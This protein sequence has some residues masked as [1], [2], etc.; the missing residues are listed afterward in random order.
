MDKP[1]LRRQLQDKLLA[2]RPE[3]RDR[4]SRQACERLVATEQF[5]NSSTVMLF[6][7]LPY[8]VD[9]SEAIL[10]AWQ[11][12]KTVAVPKVSWE[13]KHMIPVQIK[14]LETGFSTEAL[15][16]RNPTAGVPIPLGDIDLVV[17][18]GLGFDRQGNRLGRGGAYYDRFF[19]H[20]ELRACRCGFAFAEQ[21]IDAL[22]VTEHDQPVDLLVTDKEIM[23]FGNRKG[24]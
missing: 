18:P 15:G 8:E 12:G 2:L 1:Q 5:Q 6:V 21:V 23:H 14:S 4:K 19:A 13:Q 7:S 17:T 11:L 24:E 22:P 9:T 3:Q 16:L 10:N 20:D